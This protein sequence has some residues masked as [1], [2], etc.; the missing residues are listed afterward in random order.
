MDILT[1][2]SM[3]SVVLTKLSVQSWLAV[4]SKV[5]ASDG[6][7]KI[8]LNASGL[9]ALMFHSGF[10]PAASIDC[11]GLYLFQINSLM[12]SQLLYFKKS[13]TSLCSVISEQLLSY[14]TVCFHSLADVWTHGQT[15]VTHPR[16]AILSLWVL[17]LLWPEG[18]RGDAQMR[19]S[20]TSSSGRFVVVGGV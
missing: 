5:S 10:H 20:L 12:W 14:T 6:F 4:V 9:D 19:Q 15:V 8:Q 1:D 3:L 2:H 13:F 11:W 18:W 16:L 7:L 17:L